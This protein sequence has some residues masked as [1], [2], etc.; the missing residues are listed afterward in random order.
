MLLIN[1]V[2]KKNNK[3]REKFTKWVT[4]SI[5]Y[6]LPQTVYPTTWWLTT[7]VIDYF[8]WF[9]GL[10]GIGSCEGPD[11]AAR[12]A[13][14]HLSLWTTLRG[15]PFS[16][17]LGFPFGMAFG[18]QEGMLQS[19]TLY[20]H[21]TSNVPLEK[22][23]HMSKPGV[24]VGRGTIKVW[25]LGDMGHWRPQQVTK[26][27][28]DDQIWTSILTMHS[29]ITIKHNWEVNDTGEKWIVWIISHFSNTIQFIILP[30]KNI[31]LK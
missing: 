17:E 30:R 6:P 24:R 4:C 31:N 20:L 27:Y 23:D 10:I 12:T 29:N 28:L 15:L 8:S 5:G 2:I 16:H 11:L 9:F 13:A 19:I 3:W 21:H 25:M 26:M 14:G 22:S 7:A 1:K 18:F